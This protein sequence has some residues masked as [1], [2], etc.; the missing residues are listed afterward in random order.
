MDPYIPLVDMSLPSPA[1]DFE[2]LPEHETTDTQGS[3]DS[4]WLSDPTQPSHID[5]SQPISYVSSFASSESNY[6]HLQA[7]GWQSSSPQHHNQHPPEQG[8]AHMNHDT[9][10]I[11][12]FA[13]YYQPIHFAT[14]KASIN[15]LRPVFQHPPT[16]SQPV[17]Q[18]EQTFRQPEYRSS[19]RLERHTLWQPEQQVVPQLGPPFSRGGS[20]FLLSDQR[21]NSNA[22]SSNAQSLNQ[23]T[24]GQ[25][26]RM[27]KSV[28]MVESGYGGPVIN[29]SS[30]RMAVSSY[31][32]STS[33]DFIPSKL[34][35]TPMAIDRIAQDHI[36]LP[37]Q[38]G[39]P[40]AHNVLQT[41]SHDIAT[42]KRKNMV[43]SEYVEF[44]SED[45][46]DTESA[47]EQLPTKRRRMDGSD[48]PTEDMPLVK[49]KTKADDKS[50]A[51]TEPAPPMLNKHGMYY[52]DYEDASKKPEGHLN[53]PPRDDKTL[54]R[55]PED[56][57]T[58]VK[59]LLAAMNDMSD[60][61]DKA[62]AVFKKHW[63][64]K[65][66]FYEPWRREKLCWEIVV[67]TIATLKCFQS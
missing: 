31:S 8:V 15:S 9:A 59:E 33:T 34:V 10:R 18:P 26:P 16:Q 65:P 47:M 23:R 17:Q 51:A 2:D 53:W 48:E 42:K 43:I 24:K 45:P 46:A 7:Q 38:H 67:S 4:S 61:K 63:V 39:M 30:G 54:P 12:E 25:V 40:V 13:P 29:P 50:A 27:P 62:G 20:D 58:T 66:A 55:T 41:S 19:Q 57:R 6:G 52:G 32:T 36:L 22:G 49:K 21:S 56:R 60:C 14:Q 3:Y 44:S 28:P 1:L 11:N 35:E 5:G 64:D 37:P